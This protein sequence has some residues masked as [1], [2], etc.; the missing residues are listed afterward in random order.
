MTT[1]GSKRVA[2]LVED[3]LLHKFVGGEKGQRTRKRNHFEIVPCRPEPSRGPVEPERPAIG[4]E[5]VFLHVKKGESFGAV[6]FH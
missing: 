2:D 1:A 5:A 6:E 4:Q 3:D